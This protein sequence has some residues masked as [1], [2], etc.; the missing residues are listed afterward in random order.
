MSLS[1]YVLA[2]SLRSKKS[3]ATIVSQEGPTRSSS[4]GTI[5]RMN[6][7]ARLKQFW[8]FATGRWIS[9]AMWSRPFGQPGA[10]AT[11]M[12]SER[13]FTFLFPDP[14]SVQHPPYT[15]YHSSANHPAVE[16]L[17]GVE[18][19]AVNAE[20]YFVPS[21]ASASEILTNVAI[22]DMLA[23]AADDPRFYEL[24]CNPRSIS[25][26]ASVPEFS[27]SFDFVYPFASSE[28]S[29]SDSE[30]VNGS[31]RRSREVSPELSPVVSPE[32]SRRP[33]LADSPDWQEALKSGSSRSMHIKKAMRLTSSSKVEVSLR[34]TY[35]DSPLGEDS[36][37]DDGMVVIPVLSYTSSSF[38]HPH[39][40]STIPEENENE[41]GRPSSPDTTYEDED[42]TSDTETIRFISISTRARQ[43]TAHVWAPDG[44][45]HLCVRSP[46]DV[47]GEVPAGG[48]FG[49]ER[50]WA[51]I[52]ASRTKAGASNI[53]LVTGHGPRSDSLLVFFSRALATGLVCKYRTHVGVSSGWFSAN[54]S[55]DAFARVRVP[56]D[57]S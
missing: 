21:T 10:S 17:S 56:C 47:Q 30:L 3:S 27:G 48:P 43:D 29:D 19:F 54:H 33:M 39:L 45:E 6:R 31:P 11:A 46:C 18:Y 12:D 40:L 57:H 50:E 24:S 8:A 26:L 22:Q 35:P 42:E 16:P 7:L 20:P 28:N 13:S 4:K 5:R 1:F 44:V 15:A 36:A 23:L 52:L 34:N 49:R 38:P 55:G 9:P 41:G 32:N 53:G 14:E 37:D 25:T 2:A 51:F